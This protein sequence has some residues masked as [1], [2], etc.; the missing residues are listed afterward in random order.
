MM[1]DLDGFKEYNAEYGHI[2]GDKLLKFLVTTIEKLLRKTDIAERFG[3]DEFVVIFPRTPKIDAIPI[4]NRLK[5]NIDKALSEYH[6]EM[7]LTVSMGLTTYP[8]DASSVMELFEKTDQALYYAKK[9]G[10][11]I[12]CPPGSKPT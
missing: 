7:P 12:P 10:G 6:G 3:G 9:G 11:T 4:S 8:D 5:E 1:F 2:S